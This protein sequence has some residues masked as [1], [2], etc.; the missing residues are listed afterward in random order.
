[1]LRISTYWIAKISAQEKVGLSLLNFVVL[2]TLNWPM[3]I[4]IM[5]FRR[6]TKF[7]GKRD[8][9]SSVMEPDYSGIGKGSTA[10]SKSICRSKKLCNET[11]DLRRPYLLYT[12]PY[13]WHT[14]DWAFEIRTNKGEIIYQ[15]YQTSQEVLTVHRPDLWFVKQV[16]KKR[17]MGRKRRGKELSLGPLSGSALFPL[18]IIAHIDILCVLLLVPFPITLVLF[19]PE[20]QGDP[21]S[22]TSANHSTPF[23]R[24][25]EQRLLFATLSFNLSLINKLGSELAPVLPVF[26]SLLY[27]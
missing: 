3:F 14:D 27:T 4:T 1:M 18:G 20:L 10:K 15:A 5:K 22:Y 6:Q 16:R 2:R 12:V 9:F 21:Y 7:I 13:H 26:L 23:T 24:K 11:S 19:F 8:L 17:R 25:H